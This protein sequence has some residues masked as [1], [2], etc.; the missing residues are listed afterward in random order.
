MCCITKLFNL[1]GST[2]MLNILSD[3]LLASAMSISLEITVDC[4][5]N[6]IMI[7][8]LSTML[9]LDLKLVYKTPFLGRPVDID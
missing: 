8:V 2:L 9:V 5:Y 4:I 3:Q 7:Y 1:N 6:V